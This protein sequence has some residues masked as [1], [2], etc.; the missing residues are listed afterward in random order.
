MHRSIPFT[1]PDYRLLGSGSLRTAEIVVPALLD[2][3]G[4]TSVVDF[5]CGTGAWLSVFRTLGI[6]DVHGLD[7]GRP[8]PEQLQISPDHITLTNFEQPVDLGRRFDL[9]MSV[10]VAEHLP[11]SMAATFVGS[12]VKHSDLVLFSAAIPGQ[13]GVHHINEQWPSYWASLFASHEM[14]CF[15]PFRLRFWAHEQVEWWYAQN[16]LVYAR[17]AAAAGLRVAG[18]PA[19][20][21]LSLVH[22]SQYDRWRRPGVR[23]AL[24]G[25]RFATVQRLSRR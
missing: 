1:G 16:L 13:G 17:G 9:A 24:Q 19:V 3:F 25:M 12:I 15:D 18:F 8:T 10:E 23:T 4:A 11:D 5:G 7:A 2:A 22:P 20:V 14:A 6:T 21:P